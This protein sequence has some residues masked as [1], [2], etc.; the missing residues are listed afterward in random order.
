MS[1]QEQ[2]FENH[3]KLVP[4]YHLWAT[5]LLILPTLYFGFLAVTGFTVER[6]ALFAFSVGVVV[7]A[8]FTRLFPLGVQDRV[9]RLEERMRL[10]AS[11]CWRPAREHHGVHHRAAHRPP[12][13]LR[14]GARRARR[15]SPRT[16]DGGS[17]GDQAS[18]QGVAGGPSAHIGG[19]AQACGSPSIAGFQT[20][21]CGRR[22]TVRCVPSRGG[23]RT[24]APALTSARS[25]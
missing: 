13:R 4:A 14:R 9:I 10:A 18:G 21:R 3:G 5:G 24:V 6:L 19:V 20:G 2:N 12:L 22:S 23:W 25:G 11:A 8:F 1:G 15:P 17:Q 16:G 7:I